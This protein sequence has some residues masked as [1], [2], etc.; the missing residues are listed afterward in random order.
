MQHTK[1]FRRSTLQVG[2]T[3]IEVMITVAIVAILAAVA[4]PAYTDYITRG[5]IPEATAGLSERQVRMEQFFQ[6]NRTYANALPCASFAAKHFTFSCDSA[7]A[8]AFALVATG[9]GP[10]AGFKY[11]V[12]QSGAKKTEAVPTGWD[13]PSPNDCWVTKKG[14]VC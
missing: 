11:S 9:T 5:H 7:T 6:D 2:F 14:G 4:M 1:A 8:T 12:D 13:L 10:M 3:L